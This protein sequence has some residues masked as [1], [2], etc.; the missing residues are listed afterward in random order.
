VLV[1]PVEPGT[2]RRTVRR[3]VDGDDRAPALRQVGSETTD[4]Q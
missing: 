3:V 1:K 2:L 4:L